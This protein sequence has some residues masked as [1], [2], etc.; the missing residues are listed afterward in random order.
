MSC[1]CLPSA[2]VKG[3]VTTIGLVIFLKKNFSFVCVCICK[4]G[5]TCAYGDQKTILG[6]GA[7]L[8]PCAGRD[9]GIFCGLCCVSQA[10]LAFELPRVLLSPLPFSLLNTGITDVCYCAQLSHGFWGLNSV[11][12]TCSTSALLFFCP[13]TGYFHFPAKNVKS[14]ATA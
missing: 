5:C 1:L 11:P 7:C 12:L 8:S 13:R 3:V 2:G 6:V 4:R 9:L 10:S 14:D